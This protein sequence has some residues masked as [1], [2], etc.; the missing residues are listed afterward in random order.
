MKR[1]KLSRRETSD[2]GPAVLLGAPWHEN[3]KLYNAVLL[4]T[5]GRIGAKIFK[6]DLP[7]YG[8][9]DEKRVFA[10]G[11]LP[12]PIYFRGH[13]LGVMIWVKICGVRRSPSI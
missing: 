12:T 13:K 11:I 6:H 9:F 7:N 3:G 2:K 5:E 10:P 8:V 1:S 4:L